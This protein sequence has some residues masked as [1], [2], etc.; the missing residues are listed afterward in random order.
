M[1]PARGSCRQILRLP[2]ICVD[3]KSLHRLYPVKALF[4]FTIKKQC[5]FI[6]H[7]TIP[8]ISNRRYIPLDISLTEGVRSSCRDPE[9][10]VRGRA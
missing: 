10:P 6:P 7:R 4:L 2:Q 5:A 9:W 8:L 3:Q 1:F